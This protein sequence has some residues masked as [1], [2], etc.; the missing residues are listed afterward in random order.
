MNKEKRKLQ[1][2]VGAIVLAAGASSRMGRPKALLPY[3]G[4]LFID[5]I[6]ENLSAAGCAP[7][8][9]VLGNNAQEIVERSLAKR[10]PYVLNIH[11]EA[12][13]LSSVKQGI[14][15]IPAECS[16]VVVA[17][18]DHPFVTRATYRQLIQR[19]A[20]QPERIIIPAYRGRHGH[21]VCAGRFVFEDIV[22]TPDTSSLRAVFQKHKENI[23]YLDVNDAGIVLDVDTPEDYARRV[24]E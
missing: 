4:T 16:S 3:N 7:V 2:Q 6:L 5:L 15:R 1:P 17:L 11:P 12:G 10:Y 24:K 20:E 18:T 8:I 19:A 21:P 14:K 22:N 23:L 13:M 9:P